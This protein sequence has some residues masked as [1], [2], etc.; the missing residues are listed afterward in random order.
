[1]CAVAARAGRRGALPGPVVGVV[2][3]G[4]PVNAAGP[5]GDGVGVAVVAGRRGQLGFV[6]ELLE[7]GQI[8]VAVR[9]RHPELTVNR[10]PPGRRVHDEPGRLGLERRGVAV[11]GETGVRVLGRRRA[12]ER[13]EQGPRT[14]RDAEIGAGLKEALQCLHPVFAS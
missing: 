10:G 13:E 9:A 14:E 1:M 11:A 8:R 12:A 5:L 2:G 7:A 6:G 4:V 3:E